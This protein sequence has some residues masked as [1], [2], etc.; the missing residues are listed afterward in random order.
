MGKW[1][2]Y[3]VLW[4]GLVCIAC[5][6]LMI[7]MMRMWRR[8]ARYHNDSTSVTKVRNSIIYYFTSY[9][10]IGQHSFIVDGGGAYILSVLC[11]RS[12]LL[13][14]CLLIIYTIFHSAG[15]HLKARILVIF[16]LLVYKALPPA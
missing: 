5:D 10:I 7:M 9:Y 14:L 15:R 1:R 3:G 6:D 16:V 13:N 11:G 12:Q 8:E 2:W 4:A